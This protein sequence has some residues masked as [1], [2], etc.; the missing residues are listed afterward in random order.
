[1]PIR[2]EHGRARRLV[3][4]EGGG[5]RMTVAVAAHRDDDDARSRGVQKLPRDTVVAPVV[6]RLEQRH[7]ADGAP[8]HQM[9]QLPHLRIAA[10]ESPELSEPHEQGDGAVVVVRRAP[11]E[12]RQNIDFD[13]AERERPG[14][15]LQVGDL[16]TRVEGGEQPP[17]GLRRVRLPVVHVEADR[18]RRDDAGHAADVVRVGV[19]RDEQIDLAHAELPQERDDV[20]ASRVHERGPATRRLD[21][22]G[23]RLSDIEERDAQYGVRTGGRD[24][25]GRRDDGRGEEGGKGG[26]GKGAAKPLPAPPYRWLLCDP[27]AHAGQVSRPLMARQVGRGSVTALPCAAG[28]AGITVRLSRFPQFPPSLRRF[29]W[30]SSRSPHGP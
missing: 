7:L 25:R 21:E 22:D 12:Q 3:G 19:R 16:R 8:A 17:V 2:A 24:G 13:L 14:R 30:R 15:G 18:E 26:D 9:R 10:Q 23:I 4:P 20:V 28:S 11:R 1:M 27:E 5:S 6:G 29:R